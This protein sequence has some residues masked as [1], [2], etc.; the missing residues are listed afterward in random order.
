MQ[1]HSHYRGPGVE[2]RKKG[3]EELFEEVIAGNF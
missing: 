2:E 1:Q 3:R